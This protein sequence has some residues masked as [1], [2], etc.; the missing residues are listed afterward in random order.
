[1]RPRTFT[2]SLLLAALALLMVPLLVASAAWL[3]AEKQRGR[4]LHDLREARREEAAREEAR[5]R[6]EQEEAASQICASLSAYGFDDVFDLG[7]AY[8]NVEGEVRAIADREC[9]AASLIA[10]NN[11]LLEALSEGIALGDCVIEG[12]SVRAGLTVRNPVDYPIDVRLHVAI[13]SG[14]LLIDEQVLVE[15]A[16][17]AG[18]ERA[19]A[20]AFQILDQ[21]VTHCR[22][23]RLAAI[24]SR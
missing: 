11:A 18:E 1:M 9:N 15:S 19:G 13:L 6:A 3:T 23:T 7:R 5:V 16:V 14:D 12:S 20:L 8:R 17:Q 4:D 10:K 24:P 2:P 22:V 21:G